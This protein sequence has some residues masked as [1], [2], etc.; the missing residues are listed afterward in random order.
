MRPTTVA[1][2]TSRRSSASLSGSSRPSTGGPRHG[3]A[4]VGGD[5]GHRGGGVARDHAQLDAL[6]QQEG[7]RSRGR[8]GAAPRPAPRGPAAAGPRGAGSRGRAASAPPGPR[9][10]P[11]PAARPRP[12][13]APAPP[14]PRP[15]SKCSGAP[16]HERAATQAHA[17]PAPPR[18][19]GHDVAH[20]LRR[21]PDERRRSASR[22]LLPAGELAAKRPSDGRELVLLDAVGRHQ[23]HHAQALLG[24]RAGLVQAD[25]VGRRQ[26]LDGV[27][28]LAERAAP[29][30]PHRWR[31]RRSARSAAPGPRGRS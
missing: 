20:R 1:S 7:D 15:R 8:R 27:E 18:G 12:R 21:R 29:R 11:A 16:E 14:A 9:R 4:R 2:R 3:D 22:V 19:E 30:H 13:P 31:S 6:L 26:R 23:L 28:L 17:A 5:R 24:E 25:H 10:A